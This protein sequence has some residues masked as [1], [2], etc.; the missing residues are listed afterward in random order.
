MFYLSIFIIC[1]LSSSFF[2]LLFHQFKPAGL[3]GGV[4]NAVCPYSWEYWCQDSIQAV[5][6]RVF[7][8]NTARHGK[9]CW[10][11]VGGVPAACSS[12]S[13]G[14][15]WIPVVLNKWTASPDI[16]HK[17]VHPLLL[18]LFI[19]TSRASCSSSAPPWRFSV[20]SSF[21]SSWSR[22]AFSCSR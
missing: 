17:S 10:W 18:L 11:R 4:A 7:L 5:L 22:K 15:L 21:C 20:S 12:S 8:H 13:K 14:S 6:P 3:S 1:F 9:S 2:L 19:L 16:L